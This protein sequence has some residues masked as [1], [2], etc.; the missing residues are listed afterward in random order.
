MSTEQD[1]MF[2]EDNLD[3]LIQYMKQYEL[4]SSWN[5]DSLSLN[6][7]LLVRAKK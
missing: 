6:D 5:T 2:I 4:P 7:D 3:L 1:D